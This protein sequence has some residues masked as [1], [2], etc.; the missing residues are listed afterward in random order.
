MQISVNREH[1]PDRGAVEEAQAAAGSETTPRR[2]RSALARCA[3]RVERSSLGFT[4]R[5]SLARS[6]RPLSALPNLPSPLSAVAARRHAGSSAAR[7]RRG[8]ASAWQ[9][10]SIGDLHRRQ[11]Q[12]GEK[13][14]AAVGPTRRGKG[15]KIMAIAD[16]HGLPVACC[17][18]SASPHETKLVEATVAPRFTRA[19]PKRMIGDRAYDSDPLDQRLRQKHGIRLIAPHKHNRRRK[20]TQDGRELRRYCRRWKIERLFAWLHNFRRLVS[21]WEYHE[22]NFLGMLQL[23][24]LIILLRHL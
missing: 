6:A 17:V 5:R 12:L 24:C 13:R 19:K 2:S 10:G 3:S 14:G 4:H 15:S 21:R 22:A 23:G 20:S 16:R 9:T 18:T 11:L 8:L 1:G 7:P